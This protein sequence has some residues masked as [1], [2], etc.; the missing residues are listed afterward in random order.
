MLDGSF[1]KMLEILLSLWSMMPRL[2][3]DP[4]VEYNETY[5][6]IMDFRICAVSFTC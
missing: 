2:C 6:L 1:V 5:D 3:L 4:N